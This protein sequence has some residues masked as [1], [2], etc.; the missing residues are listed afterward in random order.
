MWMRC[1]GV[2]SRRDLRGS[3]D[4]AHLI[5]IG[6]IG[7]IAGHSVRPIWPGPR[8]IFARGR[9]ARLP[10][11]EEQDISQTTWVDVFADTDLETLVDEL[12]P[13]DAEA[14]RTVAQTLADRPGWSAALSWQGLPWRWALVYSADGV[15]G[16][17]LVYHV[18]DP[19]G[20]RVC[21]P[22]PASGKTA[23]D[24]G[25]LT[26]PVRKVVENAAIVAGFI[27]PEWASSE[28]DAVALKAIL[29]ARDPQ[30]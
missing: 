26:K 2:R 23:P 16:P 19:R 9:H 29:D 15:D 24:L 20:S 10:L 7:A 3:S 6:R 4:R 25:A 1:A 13:E 28:F 22:V 5:G 30:A 21:I 12:E 11:E 8:Q 18:P 17:G 27:W 14:F